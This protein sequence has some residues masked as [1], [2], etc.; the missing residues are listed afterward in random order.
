MAPVGRDRAWNR[1][2]F[3]ADGHGFQAR[4]L[5][6]VSLA[7][8]GAELN[9]RKA[10]ELKE[11]VP[12]LREMVAPYLRATEA[13]ADGIQQS[14]IPGVAPVT[15]KQRLDLAASKPLQGGNAPAGGMFDENALAQTDL[16]DLARQVDTLADNA[17]TYGRAVEAY[18]DCLLRRGP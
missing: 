5:G 8:Y 11:A 4:R 3:P 7:D 15:D 12:V 17:D 13:G 1:F 9:A 14:L 6:S 2:S 18:A 10:F 16:M